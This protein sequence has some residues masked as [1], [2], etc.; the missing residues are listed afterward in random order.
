MKKKYAR[1]VQ[2]GVNNRREKMAVHNA[3]ANETE[4]ERDKYKITVE[5]GG[6]Q[7]CK[8]N[9]LYTHT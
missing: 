9:F 4:R 6:R 8:P 3:L 5:Q 7:R 2:K 1:F